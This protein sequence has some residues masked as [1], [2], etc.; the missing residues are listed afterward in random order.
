MFTAREGKPLDGVNAT[1]RF[2][3]IQLR[4]G[5]REIRFHDLRH[6]AA[7]LLLAQGVDLVTVSRILGHSDIRTTAN[8]Y[9][10][11]GTALKRDAPGRMAAALAR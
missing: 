7:T 1:H 8:I 6:S 2:H 11:I 3:H 9:S 10:H 4:A 5:L